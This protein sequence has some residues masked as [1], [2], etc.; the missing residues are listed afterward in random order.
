V[1]KILSEDQRLTLR[2]L[3]DAWVFENSDRTVVAL[4]R[5]DEFV[6]ERRISSFSLRGKAHGLLKAVS[7]TGEAVDEI[8][9]L[10][11]RLLWFAG[12]Y[13]YLLGE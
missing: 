1:K 6:D 8:R 9:L 2:G 5:F 10:G 3:I 4:V 7:E 13:P 11:E 12:R